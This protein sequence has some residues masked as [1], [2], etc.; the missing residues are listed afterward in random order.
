MTE[1]LIEVKDLR[2]EYTLPDGEKVPVL[3]GV[4]LSIGRGEFVAIMGRS[5]SG[6]ST[7]M[8]ILGML[9]QPDSGSY[10]LG[11]Q[12]IAS[13]DEGALTGLRNKQIGFVFQSFNLIP[14]RTVLANVGMPLMYAGIPEWRRREIARTYLDMVGMERYADRFP[15]QLSGGQQQRIAIARALVNSPELILADEPT[16]SLD[17]K[18]GEEVME[19]LRQIHV[20][21]MTILLVTHDVSLAEMAQR[22]V[23]FN[24]GVC[25]EH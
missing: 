15:N 17:S 13:Q 11:G 10:R 18:T 9:D 5:G 23:H 7:F 8:N 19:S 24:D 4:D 12:E 3:R 16:G 22:R 14:R 21:G 1:G 2:K 25:V 20:R 6:K